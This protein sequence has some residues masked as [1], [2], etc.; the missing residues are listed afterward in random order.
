MWREGRFEINRR[1]YQVGREEFR[2]ALRQVCNRGLND[3]TN[4][5]YLKKVLVGAAEE[6][7]VRRERDFREHETQLR[8]GAQV[9]NLGHLNLDEPPRG[10]DLPADPAWRAELQRLGRQLRQPGLSEAERARRKQ[11]LEAH[12]VR[13]REMVISGQ[14]SVVSAKFKVQC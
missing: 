10:E 9:E 1:P 8:A 14:W 13:G 2:E 5:N 3:L 12:L 4:H 11:D 6:A 7:G